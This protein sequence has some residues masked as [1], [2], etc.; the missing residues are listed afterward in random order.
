MNRRFAQAATLLALFSQGGGVVSAQPTAAGVGDV[1][2]RVSESGLVHAGVTAE[3]GYDTN[4]FY[5]ESDQRVSSGMLRVIPWID[6]TNGPRQEGAPG[7]M[8][9]YTLGA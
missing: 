2:V 8:V 3:A 6:I 5:T 9:Q 4:V 1:G 7:P